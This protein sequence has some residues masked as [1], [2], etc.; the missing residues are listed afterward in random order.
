[1]PTDQPWFGPRCKKAANLKYKAWRH[2]KNN[3]TQRNRRLHKT[4]CKKMEQV[5]KWA[6]KKWRAEL[7]NKL[8]KNSLG[9]RL[10]WNC[11]KEQQG[12]G[13]DV[14]IP[15][16]RKADGSFAFK[17]SQKAEVLAEHFADKMQVAEP[18][19]ALPETPV[20]THVKLVHVKLKR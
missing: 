9:T 2:V 3:P 10:W 20:V 18:N 14:N 1:M 15:P 6:I 5:Q 11:I 8:G 19:K 13:S 4:A 17:S 7:S 12:L 16:L